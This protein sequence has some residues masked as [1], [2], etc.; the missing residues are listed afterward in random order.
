MIR[1]AEVK[2]RDAIQRLYEILCPGEPIN[3]LELMIEQI[4]NDKNNFLFV[5]EQDSIIFGTVLLTICLDPMFGLQPYGLVENIVINP[6]MRG[7]GVGKKLLEHVERFCRDLNCSKIM[8][9]SNSFRVDAH[10][11]FE[12]NGYNGSVSKGFKKYL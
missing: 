5:D 6:Q 12:A 11:F 7:K 1:E 9:L 10:R 2:D 4:K 8:L 3:V